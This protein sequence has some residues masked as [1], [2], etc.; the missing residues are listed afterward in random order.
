MKAEAEIEGG[1]P[2]WWYHEQGFAIETGE[3]GIAEELIRQARQE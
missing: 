2:T 1:W 3:I